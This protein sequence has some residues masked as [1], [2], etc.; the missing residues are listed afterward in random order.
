M[1]NGKLNFAKY[2]TVALIFCCCVLA[3]MAG[4][5]RTNMKLLQ[6]ESGVYQRFA[7]ASKEQ[8]AQLLRT[9]WTMQNHGHYIPIAFTN[10]FEFTRLAGM[11]SW[12]WRSRQIAAL[13]LAATLT[14]LL[15]RSAARI[16]QMNGFAANSFAAGFAAILTFQPLMNELIAW[17]VLFIHLIWI[18][19]VLFTLWCL[20]T[21]ANRPTEGRWV[22]LAA[23]AAYGSMHFLGLGAAV[24]VATG[25]IFCL[26]LFGIQRGHLREFGPIK[27]Q[28]IA[29]LIFLGV[30]GSAH[31]LCMF[32]LPSSSPPSPLSSKAFHASV[33]EAIALVT[34]YPLAIATSFGGVNSILPVNRQIFGDPWPF[35]ILIA[36]AAIWIGI[37]L[38]RAAFHGKTTTAL[39]AMVLHVFATTAFF[40]WIMMIGLRQIYETDRLGDYGFL[41]GP[42]YLV[43]VSFL[44][45]G[46]LLV[47]MMP[48][49]RRGGTRSAIFS[50][51]IAAAAFWS[52]YNYDKNVYSRT[53]LLTGVSQV[54]AWQQIVAVARESR[55][56]HLKIP[57]IPMAK[58]TE[59]FDFDLRYFEP[60]LRHDL[61]LSPGEH[62][63][64]IDW[65]E[66]RK[67]DRTSYEA[68]VPSLRSVIQTLGLEEARAVANN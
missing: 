25:L 65:N 42:R 60:M 47:M 56:A 20:V 37:R 55:S 21:L 50:I 61:Q 9:F 39:T 27:T 28:L 38:G 17:P 8:K 14:F 24:V 30:L 40:G 48:F 29:A 2:L 41:V 66:C 33:A 18:S 45:C 63:E 12:P 3:A 53:P 51:M 36:V 54:R 6:A 22:W 5:G 10:E 11:H 16:W 32:L 7:H 13:A 49:F 1:R 23:I 35:G 4:F 52:H 46:I 68:A 59:G 34:L 15:A 31:A 67:E 26:L 43:P 62:C 58:L 44:L 57:N 19:L 64:F